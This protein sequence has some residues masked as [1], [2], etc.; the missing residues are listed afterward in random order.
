MALKSTIFKAE[1]QVS[2][3]DRG[4][5]AE[6]ALTLAR[7]PSENDQRMMVRLLAFALFASQD[8]SFGKG[9]SSDDEPAL[10]ETDPSG[11]VRTWIE[12]G[13]PDETRIRKGANKADRAIVLSYG[14][15]AVDVWWEQISPALAR[16]DNLSVLRLSAEDAAALAGLAERGMR[17]DCTIQEGTVWV[18]QG[19]S[20]LE[21][22]PEVLKRGSGG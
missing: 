21:L 1:L 11:V 13:M 5:F 14:S 7:H 12:V 18:A 15:R 22:T 3:L 19:E 8:L 17:V 4:H 20:S 9:L 10:I 16:H 2:D 6:Y